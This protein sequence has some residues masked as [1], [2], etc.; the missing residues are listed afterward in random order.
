MKTFLLR[1]APT[2]KT[3]PM[4][5]HHHYPRTIAHVSAALLAGVCVLGLRPDARFSR[6]EAAAKKEPVFAEIPAL[7]TPVASAA[8]ATPANQ[9]VI[10]AEAAAPQ[11]EVNPGA[12]A[13]PGQKPVAKP[14]FEAPPPGGDKTLYAF[15]ATDLDLKS[16]LAAFAR[17]NSLN[18]VPDNDV[19]GTVTLDV[20]DL[21]LQQMMRALLEANDCTWR[22]EG[23]LIRVRNVETRTF[24]VDY[25]R[26]SRN[27]KGTSSATLNS[28][29][30]GSSGG[31]GGSSGGGGGGGGGAGGG[32]AGGGS[33]GGSSVNLVA[34]NAIDFWK[35]LKEELGFILTPAG[36]ASLSM[37]MTAGI[38]QVTDRPSALQRVENYLSGVDKSI[39]RQV[40]IE[41][42]IYDV[43][44]NDQFQFGIDWVHVAEAYG[45]TLGFGGGT[46]PVAA[47]SA[48]LLDSALNGLNRNVSSGTGDRP[49]TLMFQ[50]FNTAVAV[51]ALQQQGSVEVISQPHIR[52]LNNQTALVKVGTETPFFSETTTIIPSVNGNQV[53]SGDQIT[54]ITVGT[55]LAITPQISGDDW[56]SLDISPV[57]T[58]LLGT[59]TSPSRSATAPVLDTK[60]AS[61]LVR[62]RDGTTVVL[63]GL[64]QTEKSHSER[65]VPLL[66]D[67]PWLGKLFTGT[68]KNKVKKELVMFVTPRIVREDETSAPSFPELKDKDNE[69]AKHF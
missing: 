23:G 15:Q 67:I 31:G 6:A 1:Q 36:K 20:R 12:A 56:I 61:T 64:I 33:A 34:D 35:E 10:V 68:F 53:T 54:T 46:L 4:K 19:A 37:N 50:N 27:G 60:Q 14:P 17:A 24:T 47:G 38:V 11:P 5:T 58:S 42:K 57:L 39:H 55:I 66:G 40:D 29:T 51:N 32:G 26:L 25:L 52:A 13:P 43:A 65:K 49:T 28:A 45:G 9:S 30:S 59:S 69:H 62:V 22:E 21:P 44:L 3:T 2:E 16:A 48:S 8:P 7:T 41:V 18:I 63:G